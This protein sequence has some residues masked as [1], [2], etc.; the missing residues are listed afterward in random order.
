MR[1]IQITRMSSIIR[2]IY[3]SVICFGSGI[4][5]FGYVL[6]DGNRSKILKYITFSWISAAVLCSL[7]QRN[8]QKTLSERNVILITGCDSGLGFNMALYCN[9][10]LNM[11]VCAAC[12]NTRSEGALQLLA[13]CNPK[14]FLLLELD[15]RK[16]ASILHIE[17]TITNLLQSDDNLVLSYLVNNAGVMCFGEFEWQTNAIVEHQINVNLF[18]TMNFTRSFLYLA[19][20]YKTRIINV[21]S[22]CALEAL[23][24]LATY[25]ATKA[26]L[27][28]WSDSLRVEVKKY[29]VEVVNFIPGSQVMCTNIT[30]RQKQYTSE[31][32]TSFTDEQIDFYGDYFK[33]YN[34]YLNQFCG[35]KPIQIISDGNLFTE[36]RNA[37]IDYTPC[38]IYKSEPF[39]YAIYHK[40]FKYSPVYLRDWLILKFVNMPNYM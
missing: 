36:F 14:R 28:Y 38:A 2:L 1:L 11:F 4:L 37:L 30:A 24:G 3:E 39:R 32:L 5:G 12:L 8:R 29:G 10:K 17:K 26:G 7:I 19:R 23:P 40:L 18:G 21:T 16:S 9:L 33:R 13:Q 35:N 15:I 22:H 27:R 25:A 20:K 34:N 6:L 31:M